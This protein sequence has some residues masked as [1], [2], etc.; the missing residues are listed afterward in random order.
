M[1]I[2]PVINHADLLYNTNVLCMGSLPNDLRID[3]LA[4]P[5]IHRINSV[6]AELFSGNVTLNMLNSFKDYK[7][8]IPILNRILDLACPR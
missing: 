5:P 8:N 7:R 6:R 3:Q 4:H 2:A 1:S